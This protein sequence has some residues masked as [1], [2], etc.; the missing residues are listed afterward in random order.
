MTFDPKYRRYS[1]NLQK[2]IAE[3][4]D[5]ELWFPANKAH[6]LDVVVTNQLQF[7]DASELN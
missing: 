7:V 6:L 3:T 2:A 4:D 1:P 5:L